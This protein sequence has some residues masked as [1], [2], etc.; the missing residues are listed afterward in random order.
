[1]LAQI[2]RVIEMKKKLLL[3]LVALCLLV[4]G[5]SKT[6]EAKKEEKKDM[7]VNIEKNTFLRVDNV[8]LVKDELV[9]EARNLHNETLKFASIDIAIYDTTGKL[10]KVEKQYVR[11]LEVTNV[12]VF[13]VSLKDIKVGKIDIAANEIDIKDLD[14]KYYTNK[15][16]G[17]VSEEKDGKIVATIKNNSG[18]TLDQVDAVLVFRKGNNIVSAFPYTKN[19][20]KGE[21]KE[22]FYTPG[23]VVNGKTNLINY[24]KVELVINNATKR[25]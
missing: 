6:T 1:M 3:V 24:D 22:E 17:T 12:N 4:T 9:L 11:G 21:E 7:N 10:V 19:D 16:T 14:E 8:G 20:V 25:N 23:E 2:E 15:V 5:C 13:M 18:E